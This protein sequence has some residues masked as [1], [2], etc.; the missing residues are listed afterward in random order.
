MS[1]GG[2][3]KYY[4]TKHFWKNLKITK[5]IGIQVKTSILKNE[6]LS[7]YTYTEEYIILMQNIY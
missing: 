6:D 5:I 4:Q 7:R 1:T 3:S 2:Q